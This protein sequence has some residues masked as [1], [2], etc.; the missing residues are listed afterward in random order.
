MA[1][2]AKNRRSRRKLVSVAT[3]A[4]VPLRKVPKASVT[5]DPSHELTGYD[6]SALFFKNAQL[7]RHVLWSYLAMFPPMKHRDAIALE[8]AIAA[9]TELALDD[10][11]MTQS[12]KAATLQ[13]DSRIV[14]IAGE[15]DDGD[16]GLRETGPK[17]A[18]PSAN[19]E[20]QRNEPDHQCG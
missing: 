4:A 7:G 3:A 14:S 16:D 1:V 17:Q 2:P 5:I 20:G 8:N 11:G 18:A 13:P 6:I 15:C 19:L 9:A 12:L 10:H